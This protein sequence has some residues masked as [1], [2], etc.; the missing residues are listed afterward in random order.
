M[1]GVIEVDVVVLGEGPAGC[2]TAIGLA[3]RGLHV[4]M[5]AKEDKTRDKIGESLSPGAGRVLRQLGIWDQFVGDGHRPC[6]GNRSTWGEAEVRRYDF[7]SD[8]GGHAWH[9]DRRLFERRLVERAEHAGVLRIGP[10]SL[11]RVERDRGRWRLSMRPG[12]HEVSAR[13]VVDATGRASSFA[14][15]LGSHRL[16]TDRQVALVAFLST[17]RGPPEDR[18]TLVEAVERGW[19]YSAIL[20]DGRLVVSLQTDP[21]LIERQRLDRLRGWPS[22]LAKTSLT[23]SRVGDCGY[24]LDHQP[25]IVAASAGR[26][27][28][29]FG[30]DWLAVGDAAMSYDP[31]SS[32]GLTVALLA[33]LDAA[34]AAAS[35]LD[36]DCHALPGYGA[37]LGR[38]YADYETLRQAHYRSETRW[39][40]SVYWGRRRCHQLSPTS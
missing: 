10:G 23:R 27:D 25:S 26:L 20:P 29:F 32:H 16:V 39:P 4:A 15:R 11:A 12:G 5:L 2:S 33:G 28:V 31:L 9:I 6:Y 19:W 7:V 17:D 1:I 35:T 40:G 37:M 30:R 38:V 3:D 22:L 24:A 18:T 21:D 8:P 13:F 34:A 36:G 14:R